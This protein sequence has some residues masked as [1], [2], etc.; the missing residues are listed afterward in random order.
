M[1]SFSGLELPESPSK[2]TAYLEGP[3]PGVELLV[4]SFQISFEPSP[5][6]EQE[7][8]T[9]KNGNVAF[10]GDFRS[11]TANWTGMAGSEVL[12]P[13]PSSPYGSPLGPPEPFVG[14]CINSTDCQLAGPTGPYLKVQ[15][16]TQ[17]WQG[18]KQCVGWRIV[19]YCTYGVS[20]WVR[21]NKSDSREEVR[22]NTQ[23]TLRVF[24]TQR[25]NGQKV[26][27]YMIL[28][29]INASSKKW[30]CLMGSFR[31]ETDSNCSYSLKESDDAIVYFEGPPA[32]VDLWIANV[33]I[34]EQTEEMRRERIEMQKVKAK[35]TKGG[36]WVVKVINSSGKPLEGVNIKIKQR[37]S[38]FPL[39]TCVCAQ[40]LE[41]EEYRKF[42]EEKFNFVVMENELKWA[43]VE[44][45]KGLSKFDDADRI[46]KWASE[47]GLKVRGHCLVWDGELP[48][49]TE[50]LN[51][52][53]F[54]RELNFTP[55]K[56]SYS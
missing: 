21:V 53:D 35:K 5:D 12:V 24:K 18:P 14:F 10:N 23:M 29:A 4:A 30:S 9:L 45:V 28:G 25:E 37:K 54:A 33:R 27:E 48:K 42:V 8:E 38:L 1:G 40:G 6:L 32:G 49:W 20:A 22:A 46:L 52:K 51:D 36:Q 26:P 11:G 2:I 39:G 13:V 55:C 19:P 7:S 3:P 50:E 16:R 56:I 31:L 43:Y 41:L 34:V 17:T 15:N 47:K 44:Q